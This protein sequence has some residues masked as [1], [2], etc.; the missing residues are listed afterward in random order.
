[1][2]MPS[3]AV[4][5]TELRAAEAGEERQGWRQM[6]TGPG[7]LVPAILFTIFFSIIPLAYIIIVSFTEGSTFFFHNTIYTTA[8][9]RT[10]WDRYLPTV[11]TTIK[12][13]TLSS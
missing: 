5:T 12:L 3:A 8:N 2:A 9:Y 6:L 11:W 4:A 10:I 1:M 13:A 7:L